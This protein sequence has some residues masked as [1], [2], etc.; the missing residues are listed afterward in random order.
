[1]MIELIGLTDLQLFGTHGGFN[2]YFTMIDE[3]NGRNLQQSYAM[4]MIIEWGDRLSTAS[5]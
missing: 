3:L 1:M 5:S 4:D 2:D